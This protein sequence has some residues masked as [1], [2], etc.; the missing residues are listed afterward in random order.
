MLIP[1]HLVY[2]ET[3]EWVKVEDDG[4]LTVGITDFGQEQ[5]GTLVYVDMPAVG[6]QFKRGGECG[7]V[8]SNKTASDLHAPVDGEVVATNESLAQTPD[9]INGAPYEQWIFRLKPAVP[10]SAEGFL[11]AAGYI[12]LVS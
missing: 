1:D 7:I 5:L 6:K 12:K 4:T 3:H 2:A 11:D 8:E 10:F 9:A